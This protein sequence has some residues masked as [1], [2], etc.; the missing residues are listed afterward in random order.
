MVP[1]APKLKVITYHFISYRR[2]SVLNLVEIQ[3]TF[4]V[5]YNTFE[6]SWTPYLRRF[7]SLRRYDRIPSFALFHTFVV[8]LKV[9]HIVYDC[10]GYNSIS[11]HRSMVFVPARMGLYP[12][13]LSGRSLCNRVRARP[14]LAILSLSGFAH[15]IRV[16][17]IPV[18]DTA[19]HWV[20]AW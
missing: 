4:V 3:N 17:C 5:V 6:N 8:S 7:R 11:V 18:T 12:T 1:L 20:F 15:A 2:K 9:I 16:R 10:F 14:W 13:F 19:R